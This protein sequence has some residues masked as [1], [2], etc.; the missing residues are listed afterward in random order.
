MSKVVRWSAPKCVD[1][2]M[3]D[4]DYSTHFVEEREL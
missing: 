4:G 2:P 3:V 1:L